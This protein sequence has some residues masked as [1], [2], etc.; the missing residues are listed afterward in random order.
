MKKIRKEAIDQASKAEKWGLI[1]G[2]LG[3][4]GNIKVMENLQVCVFFMMIVNV[5]HEL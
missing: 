1:L 4:Q 3:R 5:D 2:T